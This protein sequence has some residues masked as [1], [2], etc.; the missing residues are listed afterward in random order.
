MI[1]IFIVD[2]WMTKYYTIYNSGCKAEY[3]ELGKC[4]KGIKF[5]HMILQEI[6][7]AKFPGLVGEDNQGTIST[8]ENMQVSQRT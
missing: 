2:W 8:A 4:E 7:L 6:N 5:V 1:D 3:N